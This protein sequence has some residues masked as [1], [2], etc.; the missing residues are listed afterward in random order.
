LQ[1]AYLKAAVTFKNAWKIPWVLEAA[2]E[3]V[4]VALEGLQVTLAVQVLEIPLVV[5]AKATATKLVT[6]MPKRF[7]TAWKK[8]MM[9]VKTLNGVT[10]ISEAV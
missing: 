3:G 2:Q 5:Q 6:M 4:V 1:N 10:A 8:E 9:N 7:V